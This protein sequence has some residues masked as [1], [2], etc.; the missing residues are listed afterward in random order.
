MNLGINIKVVV[1][2]IEEL[3]GFF[4]AILLAILLTK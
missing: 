2:E 4:L 3:F 1:M